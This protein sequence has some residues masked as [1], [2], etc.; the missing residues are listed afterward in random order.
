MNTAIF[1]VGLIIFFTGELLVFPT[2]RIVPEGIMILGV[3]VS[4]IGF[5]MRKK[6][7]SSVSSNSPRA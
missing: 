4:A 3:I 1:V 6:P 5:A 7:T 2:F